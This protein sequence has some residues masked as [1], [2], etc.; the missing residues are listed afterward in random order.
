MEVSSP[1]IQSPG[2]TNGTT[3]GHVGLDASQNGINGAEPSSSS[4]A[5]QPAIPFDTS[6]FK[7]YLQ[8][9]LPPVLGASPK[10]L[11]DGIFNDA[12][13]EDRVVKFAA[14]NGGPIYVVKI[15]ENLGAWPVINCVF[16]WVLIT[17]FMES[18]HKSV[19][20]PYSTSLGYLNFE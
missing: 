3:N 1:P 14:E 9:L 12:E 8:A 2:Y 17:F 20:C 18:N 15:K 7:S 6:V 19:H 4:S 13:F 11:Q 16:Y 10:E 5:Q